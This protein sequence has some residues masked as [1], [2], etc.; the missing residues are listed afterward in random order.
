MKSKGIFWGVFF[1]ALGVFF[2]LENTINFIIVYPFWKFWPVILILWGV[3]LVIKLDIVKKIISGINALLLVLILFSLFNQGHYFFRHRSIEYSRDDFRNK[4]SLLYEKGSDSIKTASLIIK[5]GLC[6][7]NIS[8]PDT[9][10]L[11]SVFAQNGEH[12]SL[13]R[14]DEGT[15]T[16][17]DLSLS[18]NRVSF[19][20][21]NTLDILLNKNPKWDLDVQVGVAT[22]NLDL[23]KFN[24]RDLSVNSGVTKLNLKMGSISDSSKVDIETGLSSIYIEIPQDVACKVEGDIALSSKH[25]EGLEKISKNHYESKSFESAKKKIYI[26]LNVGLSSVHIKQAEW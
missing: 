26:H 6:F 4:S 5:S 9:V 14:R 18:E 11:I 10:N 15:N 2:L 24:I 25:I 21:D 19:P 1:V 3:G 7:T 12:Y 17:L 16:D 22:V 8:E 23:T 13:N 20:R